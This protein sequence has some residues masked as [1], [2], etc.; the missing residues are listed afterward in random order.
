MKCA[1]RWNILA[2]K[3]HSIEGEERVVIWRCGVGDVTAC[4]ESVEVP[5]ASRES[6]AHLSAVQFVSKQF[7]ARKTKVRVNAR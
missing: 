6:G 4:M 7:R 5:A 3:V 1:T 2:T